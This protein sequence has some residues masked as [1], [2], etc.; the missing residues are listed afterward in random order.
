LEEFARKRGELE[1]EMENEWTKIGR[2]NAQP[3]SKQRSAVQGRTG[4]PTTSPND[5]TQ[6]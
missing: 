2:A 1:V 6:V 4:P 5:L 3:P